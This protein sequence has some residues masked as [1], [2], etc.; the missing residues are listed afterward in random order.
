MV[1][2]KPCPFCGGKARM[3]QDKSEGI[4]YRG[5]FSVWFH[6]ECEGCGARTKTCYAALPFEDEGENARPAAGGIMEAVECW[7]ERTEEKAANKTTNKT[8]KKPARMQVIGSDGEPIGTFAFCP[9]CGII[10]NQVEIDG[11]KIRE[12]AC[13]NCGTEI[14][15]EGYPHQF[16]M[17]LGKREKTDDI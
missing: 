14:N 9:N 16:G 10:L 6:V 12:K 2:L 11:K 3:K 13:R 17:N 8:T 4:Q 15:W 5:R 1:E 7:N